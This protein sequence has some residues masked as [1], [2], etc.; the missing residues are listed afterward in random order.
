MQDMETGSEWSHIL[1]QSMTGPMEGN[2]L[3]IIPSVMTNWE[4]W[5]KRY[6]NTTATMI[7]PTAREY[8]TEMLRRNGSRFGLGLVHA[9]KSR[10]WRLDLLQQQPLVNE[11]FSD[12]PVLID[13]DIESRTPVAW[14]RMVGEN[15]LTFHESAQGVQDEETNST[16]DLLR[17]VAIDGAL[18]GTRL[19]PLPAIVS[20]SAAWARF[21]PESTDWKPTSN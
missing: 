17:G 21:H 16:W 15:L 3:E 5:L 11:T 18:K 14:N 19:Q 9:G 4:S 2:S 20:F 8:D 1:G 12:L 10:F 13:F 6:P 7:R